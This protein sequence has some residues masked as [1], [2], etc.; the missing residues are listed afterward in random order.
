MWTHE[1]IPFPIK[2]PSYPT[3][4]SIPENSQT[5]FNSKCSVPYSNVKTFILSPIPTPLGIYTSTTTNLLRR[6]IILLLCS[7]LSAYCCCL[8]FQCRE[9]FGYESMSPRSMLTLRF[10]NRIWRFCMKRLDVWKETLCGALSDS[11]LFDGIILWF[12]LIAS[13][14]ISFDKP[15]LFPQI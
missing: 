11:D 4:K 2:T 15:D 5:N 14:S 10:F 3:F 8:N 12:F 6:Y 1:C 13:Q 7:C 9:E